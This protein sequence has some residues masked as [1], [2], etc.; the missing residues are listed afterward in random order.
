MKSKPK[1]PN[2]QNSVFLILL[3]T[4]F[5]ESYHRMRQSNKIRVDDLVYSNRSIELRE[6]KK[7]K[8]AHS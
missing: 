3:L 6:R 4:K 8:I 7:E 1:F 5:N 2:I